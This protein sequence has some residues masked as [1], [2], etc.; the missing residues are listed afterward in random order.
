M[1]NFTAQDVK[2]LREKTGVGMME[3]K[4]ALT[5]ADG[6]VDKAIDILRERGEAKAISKGGRIAADGMVHATAQDDV[7]VVLEVNSETDFVGKNQEFRDF[8]EQISTVIAE[9]DPTDVTELL[10]LD[11]GD[12]RTVDDALKEK[13]LKIGENIK[14]RRFHRSSGKKVSTYVHGGGSIGVLVEFDT[15][16]A[17]KPGFD[18]FSKDIALQVA[19]ASPQ[20]LDRSEVSPEVL[21]KER[22][23]LLAQALNEGK[24]Q[25]IA[26]KMV[27]GRL[28]KYYAENCL[29]EQPFVK[30]DKVKVGECIEAEAKELGGRI[31]V[32]GFVRYEKGEGIEKADGDFAS[33]VANMIK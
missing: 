7:G 22:D 19:A 33:E 10:T 30:D 27:E 28:N 17:E 31:V 4:K 25:N 18:E 21:D 13:I 24:P 11:F 3:C 16:C 12:G 20:Y 8:V 1:A 14:I 9:E 6:D 29:L 32:T 23:I 15:D 2:D 5:E 26:E